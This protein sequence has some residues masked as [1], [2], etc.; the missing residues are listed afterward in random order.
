MFAGVMLA[1]VFGLAS[2]ELRLFLPLLAAQ[3]LWINLI[4]DGA[5]LALGIDIRGPGIM[6]RS[7]R[8]HSGGV[9]SARDWWQIA[10]IGLAMMAGTLAVLDACY[11]AV[12]HLARE[13]D[14]VEYR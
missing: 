2:A 13:R 7:P 10:F 5:A 9:L 8:T 6:Q 3:L 4:T 14:Q 12:V 11:P 1:G